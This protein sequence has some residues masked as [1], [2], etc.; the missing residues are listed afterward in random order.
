MR[1]PEFA[2]AVG[3]LAGYSTERTGVEKRLGPAGAYVLGS[4]VVPW[5]ALYNLSVA[6]RLRV[7]SWRGALYE[8]RGPPPIRVV[9]R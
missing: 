3:R 4:L 7:L 2:A 9:R 1:S 6:R 5:L 8:L